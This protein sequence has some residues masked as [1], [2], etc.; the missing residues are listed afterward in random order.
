MSESLN[1]QFDKG[2]ISIRDETLSAIVP[3]SGMSGFSS[4]ITA[5]VLEAAALGIQVILVHDLSGGTSGDFLKELSFKNPQHITYCEGKFGNPGAARNRGLREVRGSWVSFWD[6]D[7]Q[8]FP[9]KYLAMINFADQKKLNFALGQ[10]QE[11]DFQ[12]KKLN[13]KSL[14]PSNRL[15]GSFGL[16]RRL[17]IW[18]FAFKQS[19]INRLHFPDCEI[20]EDQVFV[21]NCGM[22]F[23]EILF[24]REIV[25]RYTRNFPGQLTQKS[26]RY[27]TLQKLYESDL[28]LQ[29]GQLMRP[30]LINSLIVLRIWMS[31]VR[32]GRWQSQPMNLFR[33][34][35]F[36]SKML[37]LRLTKNGRA[38]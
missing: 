29:A 5:W 15:S 11:L 22:S 6:A 28:A 8:P 35:V 14:N 31:L 1:G 37:R 34:L 20:G 27:V 3:V 38:S 13:L 30:S 7:D 16:A 9:S 26:T 4:E 19:E 33:L 25:Y 24:H 21:L 32:R 36:Q 17:G 18:R 12:T 23:D 10:Y 2:V